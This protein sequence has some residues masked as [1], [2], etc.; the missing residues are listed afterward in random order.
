VVENWYNRVQVWPSGSNIPTRNITGGLN[1]PHGVFVT[2][3]GDVYVDDGYKGRVRKWTLNATRSVTVMYVSAECYGLFV[4]VNNTIYCSQSTTHLVVASSQDD[5]ANLSRIVA[6]TGSPGSASNMLHS[7]IGILIDINF[8]MYVADSNNH[9]IQLFKYGQFDATTVAGSEAVVSFA[10][11]Y[12]TGIVLDA[13]NYLFIVD[14]NN[15]RIVGSGLTG[16]RCVVGCTSEV[17]SGTD[18]LSNPWSLA[19]DSYGNMFVTDGYNK[20]IQMFIF[21]TNSCGKCANRKANPYFFMMLD[22][23]HKLKLKK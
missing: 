10:L 13:D 5:D 1:G 22:T 3:N 7:P 18:Q 12:P 21:S 19:F 17:G 11:N 15:N 16:F 4:D 6:G 20:R 8:N 9:R 2:I 14:S 23:F